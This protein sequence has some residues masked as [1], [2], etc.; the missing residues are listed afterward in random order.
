M[1]G[2]GAR[3]WSLGS[4]ASSDR[5]PLARGP[6][7][8]PADKEA[9]KLSD[10]L[11]DFHGRM[12]DKTLAAERLHQQRADDYARELDRREALRASAEELDR[13]AELQRRA[14]L[15]E[16]ERRRLESDA[17]VQTL[18]TRTALC[19]GMSE[20]ERAAWEEDERELNRL[21]SLLSRQ[22]AQFDDFSRKADTAYSIFQEREDCK[23]Q[24][25]D[26]AI[27][28]ER[29]ESQLLYNSAAFY[30]FALECEEEA[31][32]RDIVCNEELRH[33]P[34]AELMARGMASAI[35]SARDRVF[36]QLPDDDRAVLDRYSDDAKY[37]HD[38]GDLE[39][40]S[41]LRARRYAVLD[42]LVEMEALRARSRTLRAAKTRSITPL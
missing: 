9:G 11:A 24:L 5:A 30:R 36:A 1:P 40:S 19:E 32:R 10:W 16:S 12:Q 37:A 25:E 34:L 23:R 35:E 27:A 20:S 3:R 17:E 7:G 39:T 14:D 6:T 21:E 4:T 28:N 26:A 13:Q 31:A 15:A 8:L 18:A 42:D 22:A 38:H 33:I 2:E 29:A 41:Q